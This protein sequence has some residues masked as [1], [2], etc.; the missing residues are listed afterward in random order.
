MK[1]TLTQSNTN[2]SVDKSSPVVMQ[3][4]PSL[5][6]GGVERG[7]VDV[8]QALTD[9]GWRAIVVSKG[10]PMAHEVSRAGG[11]HIELPIGRKNPLTA[12]LNVNR[13]VKLIREHH[14]D[15]I[16]ARSRVP[17][18]CALGAVR[19]TD[20]KFITTFHGNYNAENSIKKF[21]NSVMAKGDRVIAISE[22]ISDQVCQ[23]YGADP[24]NVRVV[25]RSADIELFSPAA[26]SPERVIQLSETWRIPDD[27]AVVM[28]PGRLTRWKGHM[29]L[30][31]ALARLKNNKSIRCIMVGGQQGKSGY[32]RELRKAITR[33]R[34][35]SIVH[36][37]GDCRDMPAAFMLADVVVSAS[38]NAEAF[39]RV[40]VEAQAMGRP[41]IATDHGAAREIITHGENG[42]LV[43][44]NDA[45]KL[46]DVLGD[47][48]KIDSKTRNFIARRSV[49][50][51]R[52]NY[53][54]DLL[55]QRTMKVY[56]E[57]L[58]G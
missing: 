6:T 42:W 1:S 39:G 8:T 52:Q 44:P 12:Y 21:Y 50:N 9:A 18:W 54:K 45:D 58:S 51:V 35:E 34:L 31:E 4:L 28:L 32:L 5:V 37:T 19:K 7:T 22:F 23:R 29:V 25:P 55:G 13:L 40:I 53:T 38:T 46:A 56:R 43:P 26:V 15:I 41:V 36:F 47:A 30:L 11:I 20:T 48:L 10:G 33:L 2:D 3:V 57:V 14:V 16:H 49:E 27:A 17:A 24:N